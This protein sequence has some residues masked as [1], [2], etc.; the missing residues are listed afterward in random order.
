[1]KNKFR[2]SKIVFVLNRLYH[3]PIRKACKALD[4]NPTAYYNWLKLRPKRPFFE[5]LWERIVEL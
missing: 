3:C 4:M 1:M 2:E 5:R